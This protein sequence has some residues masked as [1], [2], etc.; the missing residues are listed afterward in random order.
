MDLYQ[1]DGPILGLLRPFAFGALEF[2]RGEAPSVQMV[3][4][5]HF[6]LRVQ[7][8]QR[9][10]ERLIGGPLVAKV[11]VD[12]H[13]VRPNRLATNRTARPASRAAEH[14]TGRPEGYPSS[15]DGCAR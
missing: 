5:N 2:P 8:F 13:L 6:G 4:L 10:A 7:S 14:T 1:L 11:D 3:S 9:R 12:F 15:P